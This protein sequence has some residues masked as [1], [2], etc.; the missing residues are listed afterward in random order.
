MIT[1]FTKAFQQA[2]SCASG[3]GL[4]LAL[5]LAIVLG[6]CV[7]ETTGAPF[8]ERSDPQALRDYIQLATGYLEQN[9]LVNTKRH[10]NNAADIDA[11]NSEVAALWGLVYAQEREPDLADQQ[12]RRALRI[13]PRNSKARNNYAAFLFAQNRFQD[14]YTQLESVVAD[15]AYANRAQAFENLGLA[16]LR[17]ERTDDA[18]FAFTRALQLNSN[19]LRSSLE[20]ASLHLRE[21]K[22]DLRQAGAYYRNYLSLLQLYRI[23][24]T[25]RGLWIGVQLENALGNADGARAYAAQL[26]A[27]F[28]NTPEYQQ[29]RQ[30]LD[31]NP[32]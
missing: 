23:A 1:F 5:A 2:Q 6:G 30:S 7:T 28:R 25:P 22:Q 15:T 13:D 11:N 12:F 8:G 26:E 29:Y 9:D 3:A 19:Q 24:Q 31:T 4:C 16:A 21:Q 20:L 14:A 27:G 18:E 10:L 17:L 32:Q